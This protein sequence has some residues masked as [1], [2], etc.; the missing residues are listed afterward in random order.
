MLYSEVVPKVELV[1]R[2]NQLNCQNYKISRMEICCLLIVLM[3]FSGVSVQINVMKGENTR[4]ACYRNKATTQALGSAIN[5]IIKRECLFTK[6][7]E[8]MF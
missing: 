7:F 2:K 4:S 1:Q 8:S 5:T 6:D 3:Q